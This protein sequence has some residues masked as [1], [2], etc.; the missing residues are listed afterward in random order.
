MNY[1]EFVFTITSEEDFHRDLLINALAEVGF[2]TF[3]ETSVGFNA[4]VP[5]TEF[6]QTVL[7][8]A[9]DGLDDM[10]S[11]SYEKHFI[12]KKNWNEEWESNFEPLIVKEECYVRATFHKPQPKYSY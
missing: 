7:D 5:E 3:E 12:P 2:D 8:G 4:Y 6:N 10:I 11:F 1:F 9:L